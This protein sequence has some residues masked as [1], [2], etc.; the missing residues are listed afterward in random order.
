[1]E[2]TNPSGRKGG[3]WFFLLGFSFVLAFMLPG[4][5]G[6][7]HLTIQNMERFRDVWREDRRPDLDPA[8]VDAREFEFEQAIEYEKSK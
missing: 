7:D 1:M 4:C 3:A 8:K 5:A 2:T 6:T